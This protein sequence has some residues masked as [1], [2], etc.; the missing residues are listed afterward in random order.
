VFFKKKKSSLAKLFLFAFLG[1]R[2]MT[3][4]V[5]S[6]REIEDLMNLMHGTEVVE[7]EKKDGDH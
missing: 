2:C 3:G 7:T 1:F 4:S 6:P 5:M